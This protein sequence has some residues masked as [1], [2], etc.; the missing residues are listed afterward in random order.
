[1]K[2]AAAMRPQPGETWQALALRARGLGFP[3]ASLV[4]QPDWG[5]AALV[6]LREAFDAAG[7]E[8]VE[9][10]CHCNFLT[11]S[12]EVCQR[13]FALLARA[14]RAG[15]LL[16]CDHVTTH[17]GSRHPDPNQP[18]AAHPDN[19]ADAAW[20]LLVSRVWALLDEV[21]DLGV[22]LCFE[23]HPATA[24]NTLDS[25][26]GLMADLTTVRVRVALDP[27]ML[28][29]AE[30]AADPKRT[31]A[32][33]FSALADTIGLARATDVRLAGAGDEPMA[34]PAPLGQGLLDYPTYL[35]LLN[36]LELDTPLVVPP[37]SSDDAYRAALR[38]LAEAA[39]RA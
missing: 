24:L 30:A 11:P 10:A 26:A 31:L 36:A 33:I 15:A 18:L 3:A 2:L 8:V 37:Q 12:A 4:F 16:N 19:W 39:K 13:N 28:F 38:F 27:A 1:M 6:A 5:E 7:V 22:R 9:L 32:E 29:T 23:P 34:E 21:E 17:A 20:D 35:R 25:L 14:M